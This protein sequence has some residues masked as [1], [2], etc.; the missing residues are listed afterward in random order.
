MIRLTLWCTGLMVC[1]T[2]G[3]ALGRAPLI[4]PPTPPPC[5]ADGTCYPKTGEWGYYPARWRTWPGVNLEPTPSK[6][7]TAADDQ[8]SPELGRSET[9][10]ADLEDA[11]APPSSPR[12][13]ESEEAPPVPGGEPPAGGKPESALPN[14]PLPDAETA[15]PF[16][17]T[18]DSDP[19]PAL[20]KS[21]L[22][23]RTAPDRRPVAKMAGPRSAAARV[24]TSDPP[25]VPPWAQS[26]SL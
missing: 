1:G 3:L 12:R 5:A 4:D 24:S 25:P 8:V 9:P 17:P 6:S 16:G 10:P 26:V 21:L 7:P 18:S 19:P 11:A 23:Q 2:T 22:S 20:P 13:E 14:V 15:A